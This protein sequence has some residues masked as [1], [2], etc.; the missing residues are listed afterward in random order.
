PPRP[1]ARPVR[2]AAGT[3][4]PDAQA[5]LRAVTQ[6]SNNP[7]VVLLSEEFSQAATLVMVGVGPGKA[8][9]KCLASR[10]R[11]SEVN[12]LRN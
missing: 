4:S 8:P 11:V 7:D 10:G 6:Q 12:S 5:C 9:W 3:P 2:P 1:P